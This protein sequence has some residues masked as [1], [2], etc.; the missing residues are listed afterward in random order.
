MDLEIERPNNPGSIDGLRSLE[1]VNIDSLD[2]STTS[3]TSNITYQYDHWATL[4]TRGSARTERHYSQIKNDNPPPDASLSEHDEKTMA[5]M[6]T[7]I[8]KSQ[9]KTTVSLAKRDL[10]MSDHNTNFCKPCRRISDGNGSLVLPMTE[11]EDELYYSYWD[12]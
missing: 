6:S 5:F 10:T 7:K 8:F 4:V 3:F 9:T 1:N 2:G 11:Q 12:S